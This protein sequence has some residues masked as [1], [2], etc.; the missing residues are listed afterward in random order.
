MEKTLSGTGVAALTV[1]ATG[2]YGPGD[3][4]LVVDGESAAFDEP[5]DIESDDL[6]VVVETA[7]GTNGWL[8][9]SH[10]FELL[11]DTALDTRAPTL[12]ISL[13]DRYVGGT[14]KLR[15]SAA[16]GETFVEATATFGILAE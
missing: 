5:V 9:L 4:D 2:D 12:A 10:A 13:P 16:A 1:T 14:Y 6:T 7:T 3:A 15:V 11:W 8:W